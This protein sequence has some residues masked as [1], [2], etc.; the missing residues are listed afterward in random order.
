MGNGAFRSLG[1]LV[2]TVSCSVAAVVAAAAGATERVVAAIMR[3][4]GRGVVRLG[5]WEVRLEGV[6]HLPEG[7]AILVANHQSLADIP[8]LLSA[9]PGEVRFLAKREL[10]AIPL[11]GRAMVRAGNLLVDR[12]DPRDAVR[13]IRDATGRIGRG[14]RL[15]VFPEGTRSPDGRVGEFKP[16][17]FHLAQKTGAPVLPVR[18]DGTCRALPK[19][20]LRIRPGCMTVRILPPLQAAHGELP[21]KQEMARQ[22]REAILASGPSGCGASSPGGTVL[23]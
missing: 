2:L 8:L 17:A 9:I 4:W 12:D 19:G 3:R 11:F 5:K 1:I 14:Q 10:G 15:V 16:G 13:M 6:S 21:A 18:I 7:G 20:S 22:A 23:S